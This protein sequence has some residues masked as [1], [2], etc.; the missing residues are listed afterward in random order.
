[1]RDGDVGK[2]KH[3]V[4]R[5]AAGVVL[6]TTLVSVYY[7]LSSRRVE[8]CSMGEMEISLLGLVFDVVRVGDSDALG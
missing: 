5:S 2:L 6:P 8:V 7:F 3:K 4:I 1:M